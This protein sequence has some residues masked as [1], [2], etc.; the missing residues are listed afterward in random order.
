MSCLR[1]D[2][3]WTK[4]AGWHPTPDV[5]VKFNSEPPKALEAMNNARL[6]QEEGIA[7]AAIKEYGQVCK[8]F[9]KTMFAS[10]AYYQ[11]GRIKME[12]CQFNDA[13]K[14]F[15]TII[16]QYP[17]YPHFNDV[18]HAEFEIAR[19]LKSGERP[20][21]FGVIPGFRD[22]QAAVNFYEK[23]IQDA[24]YSDIAPL[25]LMH[26]GE[27]AA[28]KN[29]MMDAISAF[30]RL[31]DE[32]PY[33]EYAPEAYYRLGEIYSTMVKSPLYDQGATKLALNYYED[34]LTL[35]PSHELADKA[36][37][38]CE[39]MK[40]KLAKSKM[41]VGDFYFNARNNRRAAIMMYRETENFLPDSEIAA[42]VNRKI[43]H[44]KAGNLPHRTPVDFLFGRYKRPTDEDDSEVGD[45]NTETFGL[46]EDIFP[47]ELVRINSNDDS[48]GKLSADPSENHLKPEE[49]FLEVGPNRT[50]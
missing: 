36:R 19:L 33:S 25:A 1:A 11:I 20:K 28:G 9:P 45:N 34:F 47:N 8:N 6:A 22:Y 26:I 31:I 27:F 17:E 30:G 15:N 18:L 39:A 43:Q 7:S 10:E 12:K 16:K 38:G 21:Y 5:A 42:E 44:I 23:V 3:L 13:F 4:E 46:P 2:L 50:F 29:K 49:S 40:I 35:Y 24:P 48:S 14:A 37:E 32:Y 41:L